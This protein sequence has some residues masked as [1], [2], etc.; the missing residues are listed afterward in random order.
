[1]RERAN[2]VLGDAAETKASRKNRRATRD[3]GDRFTGALHHLVH[4]CG[5]LVGTLALLKAPCE[6]TAHALAH[7]RSGS[8]RAH[9]ARP[10]SRSVRLRASARGQ[11]PQG[12]AAMRF[13][14]PASYG[15]ARFSPPQ[16]VGRDS[17]PGEVDVNASILDRAWRLHEGTESAL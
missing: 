13:V 3:V 9:G 8:V 2:R 5:R 15:S 11:V 6:R 14:L 17:L 10:R 16:H 12:G 4:R 7:A 1:L